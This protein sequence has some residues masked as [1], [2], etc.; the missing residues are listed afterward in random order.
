MNKVADKLKHEL[1]KLP[2]AER[3]RLAEFPFTSVDTDEADNLDELWEEELERRIADLDSGKVKPVPWEEVRNRL[4][5][6]YK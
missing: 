3:V 6:K 2:A 1:L 5:K 4:R